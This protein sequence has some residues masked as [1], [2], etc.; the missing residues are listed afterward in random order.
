MKHLASKIFTRQTL[1]SVNKSVISAVAIILLLSLSSFAFVFATPIQYPNTTMPPR[2]TQCAVGASPTLI[3]LSQQVLVNILVYPAPSGPTYYAQNLVGLQ[4]GFANI[5]CTITSPD[6]TS[7]TF[8]PVDYTIQHSGASGA[9]TPGLSEIVG[10][11]E[12]YYTPTELGNYSIT[13][14]F[15]G[16]TYTTANQYKNLNDSVYYQPSTSANTAV[17]T[18]QNTTVLGG[19]LNGYPWQPLPT[20]YWTNPVY[21][22]NREWAAISGAW[23]L[24]YYNQQAS[25]Y[26]SFSTAPTTDHIVWSSVT[27]AAGLVGGVFGSLAYT[28]SA[29]AGNIIL[30]GNIYQ[31]DP[32]L[33]GYFECVSLRTGQVLF[34]AP[35]AGSTASLAGAEQWNA[36]YQTSTNVQEGG[37]SQWLWGTLTGATASSWYQYSP[38]SGA[39]TRNITGAPTDLTLVKYENGGTLFY[40]IETN[41]AQWNS[42]SSPLALPYVNLICWNMSRLTSENALGTGT[43]TVNTWVTGIQWN[44]SCTKLPGQVVNV[45]DGLGPQGP[46]CFVFPAAGAD[47]VV[48]V[49]SRNDMQLMDGFDATTGALMWVNNATVVDLAVCDQGIAASPSGPM[50]LVSPFAAWYAYDPLTGR[51]IWT[52]STGNLPWSML[53]NTAYYVYDNNTFFGGSYDGHVYAYNAQTGALVWQSQYAADSTAETIYGNQV[54]NAKE[55]G[56]GGLIFAPTY[57]T[58][59]L[60][61][62]TRFHALYA[63]NESTGQ[64]VWTLPIDIQ[65]TAIAYGYLVG[66]DAENG[67]QYVIG[68]GQTA[69]TVTAPTVSVTAGTS[70]LIQGT[71][72]D[73][74]PGQPNTPAISDANMSVWMDYLH[75]QNATLINAPP[76]CNGVQVTLTAVSPSGAA[77][78]IATVSSDGS[79]TFATSFAPT[80]PGLYTIYA[81]F[82]GSGS[83]Y[84]SYAETHLIVASAPTATATPTATTAAPSSSV[85]NSDVVTYLV[86]GVVAIII[87]IAIA[88]IL[89]LRKHP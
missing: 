58:Y 5:S 43:T 23:A 54:F 89:M 8:M 75:G 4:E 65:P 60:E 38:L 55:I 13:A 30:N 71:V 6:G 7:N 85:T 28:A 88:T 63:I 81:T 21:T 40:C 47:G 79:G 69:T 12:F 45:G 24:P 14:S 20:G 72:M 2:A 42:T 76:V 67:I 73:T 59:S 15:P 37:V 33:A 36:P 61:P 44:V 86:V 78:T 11:L 48:V 1:F 25:N 68:M 66:S 34:T 57:T 19:I 64:F 41:I 87:A 32:F 51:Q 49:K 27:G 17:F 70:A 52:G 74:S 62:R 84:G 82:S 3:G 9:G 22:N 80:T 77:S 46:D 18:V 83:Y 31:N 35:Y 56:A 26:N 10:S 39:V 16:Q 53:P 29:A 50:I